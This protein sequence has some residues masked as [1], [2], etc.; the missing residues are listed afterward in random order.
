[1]RKIRSMF[2]VLAFAGAALVLGATAPNAWADYAC[3]FPNGTCQ[4]RA[5]EYS[6]MQC[7]GTTFH[8]GK[9]CCDVDCGGGTT[10]DCSPG[11]YKNHPEQWCS[12]N[13][14]FPGGN[15]SRNCASGAACGALITQLQARGP[16]SE[17]IRNAAKGVLDTCFGTNENSP[18][19]DDD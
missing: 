16:G 11:Y 4:E 5:D 13:P 15:L 8:E 14:D 18:C 2:S 7:G 12:S 19:E 9:Q 10:A 6:C 1:M 17:A 3:C